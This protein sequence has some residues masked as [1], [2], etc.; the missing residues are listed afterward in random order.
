MQDINDI[1]PALAST[2]GSRSGSRGVGVGNHPNPCSSTTSS[3]TL[4]RH[5]PTLQ[6]LFA[7]GDQ[8]GENPLLYSTPLSSPPQSKALACSRGGPLSRLPAAPVSFKYWIGL[9]KS[10]IKRRQQQLKVLDCTCT[11]RQRPGTP[12]R[13][14]RRAED[15]EKEEEDSCA[16]QQQEQEN[17]LPNLLLHCPTLPVSLDYFRGSDSYLQLPSSLL[18]TIRPPPSSNSVPELDTQ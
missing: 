6:T 15:H 10:Q 9:E 2:G 7:I 12:P 13:G 16:A 4:P 5:L 17:H 3:G 11:R 8:S 14:R 18:D 1:C